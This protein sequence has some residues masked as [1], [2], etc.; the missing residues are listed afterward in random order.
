[1]IFQVKV[2]RSYTSSYLYEMKEGVQEPGKIFNPIGMVNRDLGLFLVNIPKNGSTSI[3]MSFGLNEHTHLSGVD[4]DAFKIVAVIRNP[5][6]RIASSFLEILKRPVKKE[7]RK[8]FLWMAHN[9]ERFESFVDCLVSE[10]VFDQHVIKQSD[11]LLCSDGSLYKFDYLILFDRF[12]WEVDLMSH[13][14]GSEIKVSHHNAS[15][16]SVEEVRNWILNDEGL[17]E[18]ILGFYAEDW[19]IYNEVLSSRSK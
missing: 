14:I 11:R 7:K 18:K 12:S 10:G 19:R 5:L 4:R 16:D 9:K 13:L 3:R 6:D 8:Q 1:M 15:T 2:S 17:K